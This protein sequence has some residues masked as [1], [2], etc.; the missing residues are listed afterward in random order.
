MIPTQIWFFIAIIA[1]AQGFFVGLVL[2]FNKKLNKLKRFYFALLTICFSLWVAEFGAYW[3]PYMMEFPHLMFLSKPLPW[4][5]GPLL[6][7]F[8]KSF[9]ND[10]AILKKSQLLHFVPFL[11]R[12]GFY[13]PL[14][15]KTESEKIAILNR[16]VYTSKPNYTDEYYIF[17]LLGACQL[18]IYLILTFNLLKR[19]QQ[20]KRLMIKIMITSL[21]MFA[22][23]P[24]I[25]MVNVKYFDIHFLA[26][27]GSFILLISS[28]LIYSLSYYLMLYPQK[29]MNKDIVKYAKNKLSP[30]R[31][32]DIEQKVLDFILSKNNYRDPNVSLNAISSQIDIPTNYVSQ[33]VNT[34]FGFGVNDLVNKYRIEEVKERLFDE[35]YRHYSIVAIAMDS[36]FRNKASFYNAF[37]K[38]VGMTPTEFKNSDNRKHTS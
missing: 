17:A 6:Y 10:E 15:L 34:K 2:L 18:F 24:V 3:S 33:V 21:T 16:V 1:A 12:F 28:V 20:S 7:L 35:K 29:I 36:G 5:F 31:I 38:H 4:L 9:V 13:L 14:I 25:H 19:I 26:K 22:F 30:R 11:I 8:A 37:K 27:F 23:V 32:N